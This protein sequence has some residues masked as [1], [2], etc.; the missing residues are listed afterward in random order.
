MSTIVSGIGALAVGLALGLVFF[1]G[2]WWTLRR[3]LRS[4]SPAAWLG[5]S[6]LVRM[7]IA[8][9]TLY[10]VA[11]SGGIVSVSASLVGI[12]I[13]R[14]VITRWTRVSLPAEAR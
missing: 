6:A 14:A 8:I 13:G 11:R 10:L 12:L 7:G 1:A 4:S 5:L 2:L 3:G 9:G